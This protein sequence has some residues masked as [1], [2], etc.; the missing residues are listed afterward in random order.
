MY[1]NPKFIGDCV[2]NTIENFVERHSISKTP[3]IIRDRRYNLAKLSRCRT[4]S[5]TSFFSYSLSCASSIQP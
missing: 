1:E 3:C 2:Q 5:D 4:R